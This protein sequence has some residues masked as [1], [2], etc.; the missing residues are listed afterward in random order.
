MS[1]LSGSIKTRADCDSA[2]LRLQ[3]AMRRHCTMAMRLRTGDDPLSRGRATWSV[4]RRARLPRAP[5]ELII[6]KTPAG[7]C[8]GGP[9]RGRGRRVRWRQPRAACQC[10]GGATC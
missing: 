9:G 8:P 6:S 4:V 1:V 7:F 5:R 2:S 10:A 3:L